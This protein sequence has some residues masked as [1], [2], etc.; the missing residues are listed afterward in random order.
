MSNIF[1]DGSHFGTLFAKINVEEVE[2][3]VLEA[4]VQS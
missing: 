4:L 1:R 3:Q 2:L